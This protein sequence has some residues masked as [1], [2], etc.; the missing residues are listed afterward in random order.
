MTNENSVT[1]QFTKNH[2]LGINY[3]L[4]GKRV[5]FGMRLREGLK[6]AIEQYIIEE[7]TEEAMAH[8]IEQSVIKRLGGVAGVIVLI[9]RYVERLNRKERLIDALNPKLWSINSKFE[10]IQDKGAT[11]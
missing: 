11:Y 4:E 5:N 2:E 9:E 1:N 8:F 3:F 10:L 6:I 7:G